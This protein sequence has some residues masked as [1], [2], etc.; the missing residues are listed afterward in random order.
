LLGFVCFGD[1]VVT[2]PIMHILKF[3]ARG[4]T[5]LEKILRYKYQYL[6]Y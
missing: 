1:V 3:P 6:Q 2:G 5:F 4:L